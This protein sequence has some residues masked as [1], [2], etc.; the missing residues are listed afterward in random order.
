M[1]TPDP[2]P[3]GQLL[4]RYRTTAA[5]SQELLAERAGL[6]VRAVSDLERGLRQAPRL[7]TVRLLA[8][9]LQLGEQ[10]RT[11]LFAAARPELAVS[12][13]ALSDRASPRTALPLPATRLIGREHDITSLSDLLTQHDIRLVTLTGPGGVGKTRLALAVAD[14]MA[15]RFADGAAFVDLAP[16]R[17]PAL[18]AAAVAI[19]LGIREM[20]AQSI[21]DQIAAYLRGRA[22]LLVLDNFE[23]ILD[24][25]PLVA[26]LLATAPGL[27]VLV[28]S[29]EPL[30]LSGEQVILVGS[31]TLPISGQPIS[32]DAPRRPEAVRLFIERAHAADSSFALTA[33]NVAAVAGIVRRLDGLPLAIELAAARVRTLPPGALLTRLASQSLRFLTGGP[34]DHPDRQRTMRDTIAWSYDL[35]APTEQWLF[36][37]QSVFVGGFTLDAAAMVAAVRQPEPDVLDGVASLV[38]KSLVRRMD[39]SDG[40]PRFA[41]LETIREYGLEQLAQTGEEALARNAHVAWVLTLAEQAETGLLGRGQV[42]WMKELEVEL[43]NLRAALGW[44][45]RTGDAVTRLRLASALMWFW[46]IRGHLSEGRAWLEGALADGEDMSPAL[47]VR[48]LL[49]VSA[50][51]Q[52]QA[53]YQV[54]VAFAEASLAVAENIGDQRSIA[55]AHFM[56]GMVPQMQGD[57][58]LAVPRLEE[59]LAQWR[60]IDDRFWVG[61]ALTQLADAF[62]GLPDLDRAAALHEEA[63]VVL[64]ESGGPWPTALTLGCLG[65]VVL[66]QGDIARAEDLLRESLT[67]S[68]DVDDR[69]IVG[70]TL[71]SLAVAAERQQQP[72]CAA[73]LIGAVDGVTERIRAALSQI[74]AQAARYEHSIEVVR[75]Q[76]GNE[77]FAAARA[78]GRAMPLAEAIREAMVADASV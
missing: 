44:L 28:T 25:A 7:E 74:P 71:A 69:W 45:E 18:V 24:A 16:V 38:D 64:R 39:G 41:M 62:F 13:P 59:A 36:R 23:Q 52:G 21:A 60:Q 55:A 48:A 63:L 50:L 5:L 35:L 31:L 40:E 68:W 70:H 2:P 49:T 33:D 11:E 51:A 10:Q 34:R 73:R 9:A 76:L 72:Q 47:R 1:A 57:Y 65:N 56:R 54:T 8:D 67:L 78:A 30:R 17:D 37:S 75:A 26:D 14:T 27:R 77:A 12:P 3:I 46:Y 20:G 61:M 53:D 15:S 22:M 42:R 32:A 6:S 58:A 43:P 19:A 4:R 29:R 66:E